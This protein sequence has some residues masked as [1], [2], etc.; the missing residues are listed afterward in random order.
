MGVNSIRADKLLPLVSRILNKTEANIFGQ[1][2]GVCSS[3]S[4]FLIRGYFMTFLSVRD[5]YLKV[6]KNETVQMFFD[7]C[8][9]LSQS[10]N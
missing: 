1:F 5:L 4:I 7:D 2:L 3:S 10:T 8:V 9:A 6:K